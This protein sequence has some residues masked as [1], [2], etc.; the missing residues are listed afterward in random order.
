M[1]AKNKKSGASP[2]TYFNYINGEWLESSSG[3]TFKSINPTNLST[4]GF[5]KA[6]IKMTLTW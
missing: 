6:A 1:A 3:E 2:K 4:L 5:F